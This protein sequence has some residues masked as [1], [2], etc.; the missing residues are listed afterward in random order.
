MAEHFD[1]AAVRREFPVVQRML[2]LDAAHQTPLASSVHAA[3]ERVFE[4]GLEYAGPKPVWLKRV[5]EVRARIAHLIGA[6]AS[7]SPSRRTRPRAD[8]AGFELGI[9]KSP[10]STPSRLR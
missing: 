10:A 8:A 3:L 9:I 7:R 6:D 5:E 4:E 2:Y 1:V